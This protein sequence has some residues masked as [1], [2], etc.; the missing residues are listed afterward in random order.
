M[1]RWIATE[2]RSVFSLVKA[3]SE[4]DV[5]VARHLGRMDSDAGDGQGVLGLLAAVGSL[6][7]E[8]RWKKGEIAT[9]ENGY[10]PC[11]RVAAAAKMFQQRE[12]EKEAASPNKVAPK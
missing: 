1:S 11:R 6:Q 5:K 9:T 7:E 12:G 4:A 3:P 10:S 2:A 8:P